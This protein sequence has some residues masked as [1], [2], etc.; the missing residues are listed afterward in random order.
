[1]TVLSVIA[2]VGTG[3]VSERGSG[4]EV[5][6][7]VTRLQG[8]TPAAGSFVAP[9]GFE[10][11][12]EPRSETVFTSG[13]ASAVTESA[14]SRAQGVEDPRAAPEQ[15][16]AAVPP[17][18]ALQAALLSAGDLPG[19]CP[20][21]TRPVPSGCIPRSAGRVVYG[22][23]CRSARLATVHFRS[24]TWQR[25][26]A[27]GGDVA[28]R[29]PV[30]LGKTC[31]W[32]RYAASEWQARAR[33]ARWSLERWQETRTLQAETWLQ[34]V[35]V[36][37]RVFPGTKGWLLACSDAESNHHRWVGYGG[38][39]YST[40]LRDSD[41]VGGYLQFRFSTFTGMY[42]RAVED[43]LGYGYRVPRADLTTAWRSAL[44]Q[45]LAGGWARWS[46]NDN[47]HWSASWGRGC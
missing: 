7:T 38:V 17:S 42:R 3:A 19:R 30:V 6:E 15:V 11:H 43:V 37:Q 22:E 4:T 47:S 39:P 13:A 23:R 35:D 25:Q 45:A 41:T 18:E 34:A 1:M 46:G 12:L 14:D 26:L 2:I 5:A 10:S 28:T 44:G 40:W 32:S 9:R 24:L 29:S 21:N 8:A 27:R 31:R 33:S 16:G 36:V 20:P